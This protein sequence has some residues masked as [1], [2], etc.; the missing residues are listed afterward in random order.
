MIKMNIKDIN[1]TPPCPKCGGEAYKIWGAGWDWDYA[2]CR[3]CG[4]SV[5]LDEMTGIENGE[6]WQTKKRGL[7]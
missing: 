6:V 4:I 7:R 3:K 2:A 1:P 5:E